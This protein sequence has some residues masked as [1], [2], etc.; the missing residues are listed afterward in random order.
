MIVLKNM[1]IRGL[2][3]DADYGVSEVLTSLLEC[4]RVFMVPLLSIPHLIYSILNTNLILTIRI[5]Y[6]YWNVSHNFSIDAFAHVDP[7]G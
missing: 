6:M 2:K 3:K 4:T 7:S 5:I 1:F